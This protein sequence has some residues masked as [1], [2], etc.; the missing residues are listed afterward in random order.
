MPSQIWTPLI[1]LNLR[2]FSTEMQINL[3]V[4]ISMESQYRDWNEKVGMSGKPRLLYFRGI[5]FIKT[6]FVN[7]LQRNVLLTRLGYFYNSIF[8]HEK[9]LLYRKLRETFRCFPQHYTGMWTPNIT[10]IILLLLRSPIITFLRLSNHH[11]SPLQGT[12]ITVVWSKQL[13]IKFS[14]Y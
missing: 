4:I 5:V 10:Y 14:H 8:I 9:R 13:L 6:G 11:F 3:G 7:L 12:T 1:F 2:C